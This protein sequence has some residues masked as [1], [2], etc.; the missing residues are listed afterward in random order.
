MKQLNAFINTDEKNSL[1]TELTKYL[2]NDNIT[3]SVARNMEKH[4]KSYMYRGKTIRNM[5]TMMVEKMNVSCMVNHNNEKAVSRILGSFS[6]EVYGIE[7]AEGWNIDTFENMEHSDISIAF[8]MPFEDDLINPI[9]NEI[10]MEGGYNVSRLINLPHNIQSVIGYDTIVIDMTIRRYPMEQLRQLQQVSA[11][12]PVVILNRS[13][14]PL[15]KI[16]LIRAGFHHIYEVRDDHTIAESI[17]S[18]SSHYNE[19]KKQ[20][21]RGRV[22][23]LFDTVQ[24]LL[25]Q[26]RS[27]EILVVLDNNSM[28]HIY[29]DN[30]EIINAKYKTHKGKKALYRIF[31]YRPVSYQ[32]IDGAL[33]TTVITEP[34]TELMLS[35]RDYHDRYHNGQDKRYFMNKKLNVREPDRLEGELSS[36]LAEPRSIQEICDLSNEDDAQVIEELSAMIKQ[37]V[38]S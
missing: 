36:Y 19:T 20:M 22:N 38:I 7:L 25:L 12:I 31:S 18:I 2:N 4:E 23:D 24:T 8:V 14:T 21:V 15:D 30:G 3:F 1:L 11:G 27:G 37:G 10:C 32:F 5:A 6:D 9:Y 33:T 26:N 13:Q 29:L 16:T 17:V 34:V 28:G 35:I